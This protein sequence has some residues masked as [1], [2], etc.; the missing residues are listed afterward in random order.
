MAT[1]GFFVETVRQ[2]AL[3]AAGIPELVQHNQSRSRQVLLRGLHYQRDQPQGK[4]VR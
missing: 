4:L 2:E 1:K 3:Q